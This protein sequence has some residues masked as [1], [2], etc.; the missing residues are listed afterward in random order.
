MA[1]RPAGLAHDTQPSM[2]P[3]REPRGRICFR[4]NRHQDKLFIKL[5]F[6]GGCRHLNDSI[7]YAVG[8]DTGDGN[9]VVEIEIAAMRDEKQAA[10]GGQIVRPQSALH[11]KRA[12]AACCSLAKPLQQPHG[13]SRRTRR[14]RNLW[15]GEAQFP[16][17]LP[18]ALLIQS[19]TCSRR[20][21]QRF[22]SSSAFV[23]CAGFRTCE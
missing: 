9:P 15:F 12:P 11:Q 20:E 3:S 14:K 4:S 18:A 21:L 6:G 17:S 16:H 5:S 22:R 7:R 8:I 1:P 13:L 19:A 2:R 10:A 23:R